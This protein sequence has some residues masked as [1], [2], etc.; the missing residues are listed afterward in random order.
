[1]A[2][3]AK[4]LLRFRA[5]K[6][7]SVQVGNG[8]FWKPLGAIDFTRITSKNGTGCNGISTQLDMILGCV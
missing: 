1:M 8:F 7:L 5:E 3:A 2:P 6:A 4:Q